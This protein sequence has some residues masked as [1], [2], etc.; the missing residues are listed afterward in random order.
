MEPEAGAAFTDRIT[1]LETPIPE[2]QLMSISIQ[3]PKGGFSYVGA[4]ATVV[5]D[6]GGVPYDTEI[7]V[8][9]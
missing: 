7:G 9:G 1:E 5:V 4:R 3:P 2:S 6:G 8:Q